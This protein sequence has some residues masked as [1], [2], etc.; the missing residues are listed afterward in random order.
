MMNLSDNE[1]ADFRDAMAAMEALITE[2]LGNCRIGGKKWPV[3]VS[4]F[5]AKIEADRRY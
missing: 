5:G 4:E 3:R 2:F 1:T